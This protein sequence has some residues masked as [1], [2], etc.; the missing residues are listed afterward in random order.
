MA[1]EAFYDLCSHTVYYVETKVAS[2]DIGR[3]GED[4]EK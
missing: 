3:F 1:W 2:G 4:V